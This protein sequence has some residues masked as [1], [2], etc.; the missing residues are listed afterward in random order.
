MSRVGELPE[1]QQIS[2]D[3]NGL[4]PL[5]KVEVKSRRPDTLEDA[6]GFAYLFEYNGV[7]ILKNINASHSF[8]VKKV[9]GTTLAAP[10]P[11][12]TSS[13]KSIAL[14]V[15]KFSFAELK[16]RR[17]KGL[18]YHCDAKFFRDMLAKS[19]LHWKVTG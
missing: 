8:P 13:N 7:S 11:A 3:T 15:K 2:S 4:K 16:E 19:Y 1:Y 12:T 14:P 17:E 5:I 10:I 6:I 18:C 9:A